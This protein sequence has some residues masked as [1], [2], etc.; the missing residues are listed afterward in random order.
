MDRRGP[1]DVPVMS[2]G[3]VAAGEGRERRGL[4]LGCGG[5]GTILVKRFA[6]LE[7]MTTNPP[8]FIFINCSDKDSGPID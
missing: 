8:H 6:R 7:I 2:V 5:F 1:G 4:G 3:A